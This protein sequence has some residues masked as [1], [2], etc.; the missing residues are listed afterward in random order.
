MS[1]QY[2][3][4]N[5][6]SD[7]ADSIQQF[8]K[9]SM[10]LFSAS[11]ENN[12]KMANEMGNLLGNMGIKL[13]TFSPAKHSDCCPPEPYCPPHCLIEINR[14][15]YVGEMI[16]VPFAVK[17]TCGAAKIYRI[18]LRPLV[19]QDGTPAPIQPVLNK[20]QVELQP[21]Q[22]VN[23]LMTINLMQGVSAG[24]CFQTDIVIREKEIN[25]NICFKLK[26]VPF[27]EVPIA[28]PLDEKEYL[29]HWQS[30]QSHFYC[31]QKPRESRLNTNVTLA[32]KGTDT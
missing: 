2:S 12:M 6:T 26:V 19:N 16:V 31:E 23:I 32:R 18:G 29:N 15:A 27:C 4:K 10:D 22:S 24:D 3:N 17:N 14:E 25:Q 7:F 30:W 28:K 20:N 1:N 5:N 13:P 11:F 8:S 21:G 9:F